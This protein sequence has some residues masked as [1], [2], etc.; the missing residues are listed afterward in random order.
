VLAFNQQVNRI[1][2]D[3]LLTVYRFL[4]PPFARK[5]VANVTD[6]AGS[7]WVLVNDILQG[8]GQRAATTAGRIVVNATLGLG[9]LFEVAEGLGLPDHD[10]DFGQTLAVWGVPDGAFLIVPLLGP[11][12]VRD[13]IGLGVGV[14][15]NPVS[16]ALT[17]TG[18]E[19]ANWA[20]TGASAVVLLDASF[21]ALQG[22]EESSLDFYAALESAYRQARAA[23]IRNGAADPDALFNDPLEALDP[24]A[25]TEPPPIP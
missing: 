22:L 1:V 13:G 6:L 4:V 3:P 8:E 25:P 19:T 16:I 24:P 17:E 10:E 9:G 21:D 18:Q 11:T 23:E 20:L 12:T 15:A 2:I 5:G 14:F 7:P